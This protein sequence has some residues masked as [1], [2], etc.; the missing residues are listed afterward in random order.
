MRNTENRNKYNVKF[1]VVMEEKA[2][3]FGRKAAED[4]KLI[5]VNYDIFRQL[6]NP[7]ELNDGISVDDNTFD[8]LQTQ[9]LSPLWCHQMCSTFTLTS[10][11]TIVWTIW[12]IL[13]NGHAN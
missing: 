3:L 1:Q 5:Y 11:Y 12:Y 10:Q 2:P 6:H 4:K 7:S 8:T 13:T 9:L